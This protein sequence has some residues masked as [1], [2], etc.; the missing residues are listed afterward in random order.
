M[1]GKTC[2][3]RRVSLCIPWLLRESEVFLGFSSS[4]TDVL[5]FVIKGGSLIKEK[6]ELPLGEEHFL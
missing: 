5:C 3:C 4:T 2:R 1:K 6:L